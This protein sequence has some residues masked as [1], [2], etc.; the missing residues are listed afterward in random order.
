MTRG[1]QVTREDEQQAIILDRVKEGESWFDL[2]RQ[3]FC[4]MNS[5]NSV[6]CIAGKP[7][8]VGLGGA[9]IS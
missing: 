7:D 4:C 5:M 2:Q 8:V 3:I 6:Y 1:R 9:I